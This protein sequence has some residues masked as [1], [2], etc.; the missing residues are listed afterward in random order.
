MQP[1]CHQIDEYSNKSG[2]SHV[3]KWS[4]FFDTPPSVKTGV[5]RVIMRKTLQ[6]APG[7]PLQLNNL[8]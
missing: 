6:V 4:G 2:K 5:S 3:L 8:I 7:T 1:R